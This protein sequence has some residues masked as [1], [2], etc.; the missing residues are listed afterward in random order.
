MEKVKL[1]FTLNGRKNTYFRRFDMYG[2]PLTTT[3]INSARYIKLTE[4][5]GVIKTL[6]IEY[7][8]NNVKDIKTINE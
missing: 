6:M 7:G 4:V 2:K 1:E 3:N 8:K 5:K